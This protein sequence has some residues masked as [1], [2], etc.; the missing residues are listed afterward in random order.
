MHITE[1]IFAGACERDLPGHSGDPVLA[2][3]RQPERGPGHRQEELHRKTGHVLLNYTSS[4]QFNRAVSEPS[5]SFTVPG[6]DPLL[7]PS[8]C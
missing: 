2:R 8:S 6:E 5:Q 3:P 1:Y 7:G 4:Q